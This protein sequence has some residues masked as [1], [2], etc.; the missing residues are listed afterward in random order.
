[1]RK[2]VK[3]TLPLFLIV[4]SLCGFL[5]ALC[6][7][8]RKTKSHVRNFLLLSSA[9]MRCS[10]WWGKKVF[11][12]KKYCVCAL[13]KSWHILFLIRPPLPPIHIPSFFSLANIC[14]MLWSSHNPFFLSL[15]QYY[16][17]EWVV[18]K[19]NNYYVTKAQKYPLGS[20]FYDISWKADWK[21]LLIEKENSA[22]MHQFP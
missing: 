6:E 9:I 8:F 15:S 2:Y 20:F 18:S 16:A 10:W 3:T 19:E 13:Q 14:N 4:M 1:M 11:Y 22:T 5:F 7:I 17:I 12:I 21:L